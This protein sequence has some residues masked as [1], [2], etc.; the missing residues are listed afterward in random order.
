MYSAES[1]GRVP[2]SICIVTPDLAGPVKNGGIG[3]HVHW[4][5]RALAKRGHSVTVLFS[6]DPHDNGHAKWAKHYAALGIKLVFL[7]EVQQPD[8]PIAL[9]WELSLSYRIFIYLKAR[10]FDSIHFQDWKGNGFH[11]VMAKKAGVAFRAT[12]ITV[13]LHSSI[14]WSSDGMQYWPEHVL[15]DARIRYA[16]EFAA[17]NADVVVSPSR[18]MVDWVRQNGWS[19]PSDV[20]V[21][22]NCYAEDADD[23][24]Y[25]A[26]SGVLAFFGR[27]ETRKGLTLLIDAVR[28]MTPES[29]ARIKKLWFVGKVWFVHGQR[30]DAYISEKLAGCGLDWEI[31]GELGAEDALAFIREK[32]AIAICPSLSDNSPYTIVECSVRKIPVIAANVGGVPELLHQDGLFDPTPIA[33]RER[34]ERI[35]DEGCLP[36]RHKYEAGKAADTWSALV[37]ELAARNTLGSP[38]VHAATSSS[39]GVSVCIPFFNAGRYLDDLLHGLSR[40]EY[41]NWEVIF[42]DDAS[43]AP[44]S[45][46]E[47]KRIQSSGIKDVRFEFNEQNLGIGG[48]RNRAASLA[49]YELL[50]FIDA[51]NYPLPQMVSALV[52]A[53]QYSGAD[54]ATCMMDVFQDHQSPRDGIA[55]TDTFMPLGPALNLGVLENVFGDANFLVRKN[56]WEAVGKFS[57]RRGVGWEDWEFLARVSLKGFKQIVVPERLFW[58]RKNTTGVLANAPKFP[59]QLFILDTYAAESPPWVTKVLN[60]MVR[61]YDNYYK[62]P[63]DLDWAA[64]AVRENYV[65]EMKFVSDV[66]S[67]TRFGKF[68]RRSSA[69]QR[70]IEKIFG[71]K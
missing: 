38:N 43:T 58:Y 20:R 69:A 4:L 70:I 46:I 53:L 39:P 34:L 30:A 66:L 8:H 26:E 31:V 27:L 41:K 24:P 61:P 57:E 7:S 3:T 32:R 5:S 54:V 63:E 18:Y 59:S 68:V 29:R 23:V 62:K 28:A 17:S 48:T 11:T 40:I 2:S 51:D 37:E 14:H 33:L 19:L 25:E 50:Q 6:G 35:L 1:T 9:D 36:G 42:V 21:Q 64:Q 71:P 60:G 52:D 15:Q 22:F 47:R 10:T 65:E 12:P 55:P 13:T 67:R 56:V 49:K 16:E 44:L 45:E